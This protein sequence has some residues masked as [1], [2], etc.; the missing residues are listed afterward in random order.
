MSDRRM[1]PFDILPLGARFM[2]DEEKHGPQNRVWVKIDINIIAEWD[3]TQVD[4]NW[5]GQQICCFTDRDDEAE[6]RQEKVE[7]IQ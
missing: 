3:D 6:G 2:Y 1:I 5:V 7:F 4:T